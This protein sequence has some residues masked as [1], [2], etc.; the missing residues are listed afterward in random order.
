MKGMHILSN[1]APN[2]L[3]SMNSSIEHLTRETGPESVEPCAP[4]QG[5]QE[6]RDMRRAGT[7]VPLVVDVAHALG[8]DLVGVTRQVSWIDYD[9]DG[10]GDLRI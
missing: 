2:P 1:Q 5:G 8:V 10:D 3:K 7:R 9:N 4:E 6:S